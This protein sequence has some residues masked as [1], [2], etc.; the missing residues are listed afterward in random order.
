MNACNCKSLR[1]EKE[2]EFDATAILFEKI[3]F[4]DIIHSLIITFISTTMMMIIAD[5]V[6]MEVPLLSFCL[7]LTSGCA[8]ILAGG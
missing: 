8:N 4:I 7:L 2:L 6:M 1:E 3:I 5:N